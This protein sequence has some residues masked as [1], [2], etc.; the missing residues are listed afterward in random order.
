M[1]E[2]ILYN[3]FMLGKYYQILYSNEDIPTIG[4]YQYETMEMYEHNGKFHITSPAE[5]K[6]MMIRLAQGSGI[7][8]FLPEIKWEDF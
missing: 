6:A 4:F 7:L 2:I 1:S 8:T 3:G 5:F